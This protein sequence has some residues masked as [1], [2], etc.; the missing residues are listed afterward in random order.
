MD[1]RTIKTL[2][3]FR[4]FVV[5]FAAQFGNE[6]APRSG[7]TVIALHGDLGAGKTTFVQELAKIWGVIEP[8][9]SPTFVLQK[10]YELTGAPFRTLVHMDVYRL[11]DPSEVRVL[12]WEE[13]VH[14]SSSI[15]CV[16]WAERI[17][18][19]LPEEVLNIYIEWDG[20]DERTI[21]F[22]RITPLS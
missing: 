10:K 15:V 6:V 13:L 1:I 22:E 20:E 12:H 18:S 8:V 19:E 14:D 5:E 2:E 3:E 21:K 16:E 7:A 9:T 11:D 4:A 17:K